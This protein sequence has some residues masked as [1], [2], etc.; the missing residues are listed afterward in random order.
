MLSDHH[1]RTR[2]HLNCC[3][4]N[5]EGAVQGLHLSA[6]PENQS[7]GTASPPKGEKEE[8]RDICSRKGNKWQRITALS[9]RFRTETIVRCEKAAD[10]QPARVV[11]SYL[12]RLFRRSQQFSPSQKFFQK[13][14]TDPAFLQGTLYCLPLLSSGLV[15]SLLTSC[16]LQNEEDALVQFWKPVASR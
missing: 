14:S 11:G 9:S 3:C 7:F 12:G 6:V 10:Y 13:T 1:H 5:T 16:T 8:N 15:L 4:R 2:I